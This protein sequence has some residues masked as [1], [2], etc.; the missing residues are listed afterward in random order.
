MGGAVD[1]LV[2]SVVVPT[3]NRPDMLW[4][5]LDAL[6]PG[7]QTFP[8][9]K[10]EVIVTDDGS[11]P[12]AA[13]VNRR[14]PWVTWLAGPRRGPAA[15]RN[16]GARAARGS[17]LAFTDDDCVPGRDWLANLAGCIER[18]AG[19]QA[20]EGKVVSD[21][22]PDRNSDVVPLN[23]TGG[24]FWSCNIAVERSRFMA[25]EGFDE[26]Y[27]G[28]AMEDID[29]RYALERS[30]AQIF[31]APD[32]VINHP[33]R[34]ASTRTWIG[35]MRR[36]ASQVYFERKWHNAGATSLY[37]LMFGRITRHWLVSPLR[38]GP[39]RLAAAYYVPAILVL[40]TSFPQWYR[41]SG[42]VLAA[43]RQI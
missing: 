34:P 27:P 21:P 35:H 13:Q 40:T 26:N 41:R 5:C 37:L 39:N 42:E 29:L 12:V 18:Q 8:A 32:A 19:I 1:G 38:H 30:G 24:H 36:F 25:V 10:F 2:F 3:C 43:Q 14:S 17:W 28:P 31:F 6:A 22:A 11:S 7:R 4:R 33:P 15:N 20:I 23:L 9:S 16:N